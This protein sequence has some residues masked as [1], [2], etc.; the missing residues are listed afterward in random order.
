MKK[1]IKT[2]LVAL[3]LAAFACVPYKICK[4]G[5][6]GVKDRYECK[7]TRSITGDWKEDTIRFTKD[8]GNCI[9]DRT[10]NKEYEILIDNLCDGKVDSYYLGDKLQTREEFG[11]KYDG[12]FNK[13]KKELDYEKTIEMILK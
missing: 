6:T 4:E 12:L 11:N 9:I 2:G 7:V 3:A 5:T 13:L 8:K 10:N 1:L